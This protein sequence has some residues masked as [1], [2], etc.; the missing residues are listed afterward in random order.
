MSNTRIVAWQKY[1]ALSN[2]DA[3]NWYELYQEFN[4][5]LK[6][7]KSPTKYK[8]YAKMRN[9]Y[10]TRLL[11]WLWVITQKAYDAMTF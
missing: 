9:K 7:E 11:V 10:E 2:R 1:P 4:T 6:K 3:V 5:H 8:E